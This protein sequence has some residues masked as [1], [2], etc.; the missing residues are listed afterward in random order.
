MSMKFHHKKIMLILDISVVFCAMWLLLFRFQKKINAVT[1]RGG[2]STHDP[3]HPNQAGKA[4]GPQ[5]EE[6]PPTHDDSEDTEEETI[7]QKFIDTSFLSF[8]TQKMK[9]HRG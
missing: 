7:P 6:E 1:M 5:E 4:A 3:P 9:D 2:K 8:P